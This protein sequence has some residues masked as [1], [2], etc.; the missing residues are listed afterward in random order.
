MDLPTRTDLLNLARTYITTRAKNIDPKQVDVLGSD[1]NLFVGS[2]SVVAYEL[3]S[4]LAAAVSKL[5]VNGADGE[6]LDRL[7]WDRYQL[8][9]KPA[10]PSYAWVRFDR[11]A[12]TAGPGIVPVSTR[13][14]NNVGIDYI[15]LTSGTMAATDLASAL[16]SVRSIQA[17]KSNQAA[18]GTIKKISDIASL[19]DK[20]LTV[21]NP[22]AS[23]FGSDVELDD[24]FRGRIL[25]YW[26]TARRGTLQAIEQGALAT[27]GIASASAVEELS[28][29]AQPARLV[30]LCIAD[31]DGM[32]SG[33]ITVDLEESRA[34]G[35]QVILNRSTPLYVNVVLSL[36]FLAGKE[37][38][39][40]KDA[41]RTAMVGTVN[42]STTNG[43]LF[44]AN[45]FE[46]LKS[47]AGDGLIPSEDSIV[48][49]AGDLV[50]ATG[51]TIRTTLDRVTVV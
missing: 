45:L 29:G 51:M 32:S 26:L 39:L 12:Y 13:L 40:I 17:G 49:P 22:E 31:A 19:W 47:F 15:T 36:K 16:V 23:S 43:T 8:L 20:T 44:R 50:P 41:V 1:V 5:L 4:Q 14:Q 48:E 46:T 27:P 3:V 35:I 30:T 18:A 38:D 6:D 24:D 33:N 9:R 42:R 25:A 34:A 28:G 21:T 37:T 7:A 11:L 2:M 10:S